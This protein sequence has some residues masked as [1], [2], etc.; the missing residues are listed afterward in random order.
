MS[1]FKGGDGGPPPY[2]WMFYSI[3]ER[4]LQKGPVI[5]PNDQDDERNRD[6][7][8]KFLELDFQSPENAV[9]ATGSGLS[10]INIRSKR[11]RSGIDYDMRPDDFLQI[12][13]Y[14]IRR[15]A[16]FTNSYGLM[17]YESIGII[18]FM[19]DGELKVEMDIGNRLEPN[20]HID[21]DWKKDMRLTRIRRGIYMEP[22]NH[23]SSETCHDNVRS[24]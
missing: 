4:F 14:D 15:L 2:V 18:R 20:N 1:P 11:K 16:G 5:S 13:A 7:S 21:H 12:L 3:L 19:V 22:Q 23:E 9:Y 24:N 6:I 17:L 10:F 8:I